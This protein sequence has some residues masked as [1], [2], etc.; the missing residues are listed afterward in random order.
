M[1]AYELFSKCRQNNDGQ[2]V[3]NERQE[4]GMENVVHEGDEWEKSRD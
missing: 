3:M 2:L 1:C 4:F